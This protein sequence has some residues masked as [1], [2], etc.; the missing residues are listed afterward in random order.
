MGGTTTE[1]SIVLLTSNHRR[2]AGVPSSAFDDRQSY[3][4]YVDSYADAIEPVG[5]PSW[6]TGR[7]G[8]KHYHLRG[9]WLFDEPAP[10]PQSC[11]IRTTMTSDLITYRPGLRYS[12]LASPSQFIII[13]LS[14]FLTTRTHRHAVQHSNTLHDAAVTAHVERY[15]ASTAVISTMSLALLP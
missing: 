2:I 9:W 12:S 6:Q 14:F 5:E 13:C 4:R 1:Q 11:R 10:A 3:W 15:A 8:L 7:S